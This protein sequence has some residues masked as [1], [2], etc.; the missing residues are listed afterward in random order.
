MIIMESKK[1]LFYV[2]LILS[3]LVILSLLF[4]AIYFY[5]QNQQF[6]MQYENHISDNVFG[7]VCPIING[8][9]IV[10]PDY[11]QQNCERWAKENNI[12]IPMC[13]G[14]WEIVNGRCSWNC[15]NS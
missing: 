7:C 3:I 5:K 10:H 2:Y 15:R 4:C 14:Q 13:I 11:G 6:K 8:C 1:I 12:I 9:T